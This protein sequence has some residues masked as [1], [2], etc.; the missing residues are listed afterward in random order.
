MLISVTDIIQGK[1]APFGA[2]FTYPILMKDYERFADAKSCLMIMQKA[3]PVELI[4]MPYLHTLS[5]LSN[6]ENNLLPKLSVVLSLALRMEEERIRIAVGEDKNLS[7]LFLDDNL[8]PIQAVSA[9][10]F[11]ALRRQIAEQNHV[12]LPNEKANLEILQSEQDLADMNSAGLSPD[13]QSLFFAVA[14]ACH[15]TTQQMLDMTIYEFEERYKAINRL[16]NHRIYQQA[17]MSGMVTFKSGN[18]YP[19]WCFDKKDDG[20][21]GAVPLAQF[22]QRVGNV[23]GEKAI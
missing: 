11:S 4:S 15:F 3:L 8:K 5:I 22:Q 6:S 18:P 7:L 14:T 20:L 2:L 16:E 17:G 9:L 19:S 10:Q 1:G 21:H 13:F 23:I 12:E